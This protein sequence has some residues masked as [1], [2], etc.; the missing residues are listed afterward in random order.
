MISEP[1]FTNCVRPWELMCFWHLTNVLKSSFAPN[2]TIIP[3]YGIL[4]AV[5]VH[6]DDLWKIRAPVISAEGFNLSKF[7]EM[8]QVFVLIYAYH[9]CLQCLWFILPFSTE[10]NLSF[11]NTLIFINLNEQ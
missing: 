4:K 7:D 2:V 3:Q 8:V 11:Y 5:A 10:E 1:Y 6:F 9:F